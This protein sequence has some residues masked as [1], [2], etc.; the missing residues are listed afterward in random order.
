MDIGDCRRI[1]EACFP[2]FIVQDIRSMQQGWDSFV[3]LVN[4]SHVFRFPLRPQTERCLRS[5]I[6]LLPQLSEV[7]PVAIPEFEYVWQG[8]DKQSLAFVGYP[9]IP[10]TALSESPPFR[11]KN[12]G[13]IAELLGRTL[14][15]L[16][17]FPVS[18][19]AEAGLK[20]GSAEQWRESYREMLARH[21]K[22]SFPLMEERLQ[23]KCT[24]IFEDFLERDDYFTFEPV[25]IH[26]D[27]APDAHILWDPETEDITGI[28]DWG[29]M[30]IG[31]PAL[32]FTGIISDCGPDFAL[33]VYSH[34]GF[35]NDPTFMDRAAWYTKF[36]GFYFIEYGQIIDDDSYIESG[37]KML[38]EV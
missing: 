34:Y 38:R 29:D 16:H 24:G 35:C 32:D 28:V 25:V 31:D 10:G 11:L 22:N 26:G 6:R 19:S 5:E 20:P 1:I 33:M 18:K 9:I 36:F 2:D 23:S 14:A 13:Q 4:S 30:R 15:S 3:V 37:L 21:E 12:T 8:D 7:L 27:L 17:S